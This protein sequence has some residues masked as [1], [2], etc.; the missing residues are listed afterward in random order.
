MKRIESVTQL[1]EYGIIPLTGESD[2]HMYR[3]LCDVTKRGKAAIERTMDTALTLHENWNSGRAD[4]PHIGSILLPYEFVAP[5]AI[6][7]LLSDTTLTEVWLLKNGHVIGFGVED[8]EVKERLK[9]FHEGHVRHIFYA[10]PQDRNVHQ[11]TG[12]IS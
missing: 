12:R 5:I 2:A 3:I 8:V 11:M 9:E 7:C 1:E 4:D 6:F 10:R